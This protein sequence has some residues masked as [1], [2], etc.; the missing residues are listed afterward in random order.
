MAH[1]LHRLLQTIRDTFSNIDLLVSNTKKVFL[2]APT[3]VGTLKRKMTKL[4][5]TTKT[6]YY[7]IGNVA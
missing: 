1:G 2:K 7:P 4:K 5:F 3:R 6:Y